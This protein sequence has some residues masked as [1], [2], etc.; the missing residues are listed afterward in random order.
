MPKVQV[1]RSAA[2]WEWMMK[3]YKNC[4]LVDRDGYREASGIEVEI[5]ETVR[6]EKSEYFLSDFSHADNPDELWHANGWGII[7]NGEDNDS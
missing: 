4:V 6:I 7:L 3:L 1:T 2:A 5:G